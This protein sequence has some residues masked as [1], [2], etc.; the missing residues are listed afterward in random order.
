MISVSLWVVGVEHD[1]T[2][3]GLAVLLGGESDVSLLSPRSTPGVSDEEVV[4]SVVGTVSNSG[5]GVV[6][7]GSALL[8]VEDSTGVELEVSLGIDRDA[9][10]LLGNGG[11]KLGD[12]LVLD[13]RVSGDLNL[14]LLGGSL[15]R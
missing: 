6:E 9:S 2:D 4:L 12:A 8:G 13:V 14:L 5:D 15:A 10:W 3:T 7:V 11:L 1:T